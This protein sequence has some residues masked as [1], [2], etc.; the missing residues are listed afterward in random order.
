[1]KQSLRFKL[2]V[3]LLATV[4]TTLLVT[5]LASNLFL[6]QYYSYGKR[7]T[8]VSAFHQ[9]NTIYQNTPVTDNNVAAVPGW[10]PFGSDSINSLKSI[11]NGELAMERLSQKNNIAIMVYKIE[12]KT[13]INDTTLYDLGVVFSTMGNTSTSDS[14]SEGFNIYKDYV[15]SADRESFR[16]DSKDYSIQQ[17]YVSRLDSSYIYLNG[18]LD[19]GYYVMLRTSLQSIEDGA[20]ISNQ[21]YIYVTIGISCI[22]FIFMLF[23]SKKFTSQIL[24]LAHIAKKMSELDFDTKYPVTTEDEIG[25]L[26]QSINTLS[27]TLETTLRELKNANAQL[28]KDLD[29]KIQIDEMRK[30]FLSN[31][32]HELKT[33]IA[34]IQ[35]YA[36][37]LQENISDDQESR[38]FYCDVIMDEAAKMNGIV[39]KLLDLNQIEFGADTLNIEHFDIVDTVSNM[40]DSSD[41][42]FKQKEVTLKFES[43]DSIYVWG[44]VYLIEESFSNYL[45]NAL[46]HVDGEKIIRVKVEKQG[47]KARVSVFNTGERIPEEDIDNIWIKFYKVDKARTREYGGSGVG[48]SIVK[49]T[50]ERLGQKYG[51]ENHEDGVE[52]WFELDASENREI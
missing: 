23:I 31:V 33:P 9:I 30:E 42:L 25:V 20:A 13:E 1:M 39:K 22:S 36:E 45:S 43:E 16:T 50:M 2:S 24:D 38:E 5:V 47:D 6:E 14:T 3:T 34:L 26:G 11:V 51:V 40:V 17:V 46:N 15:R 37:G 35:G 10:E 4:L 8:L 49:A 18:M 7:N 44:D 27:E 28:K 12:G 52:F 19:N 48:L 32:S 41:I 21:F 29:E